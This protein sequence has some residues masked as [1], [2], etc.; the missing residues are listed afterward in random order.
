MTRQQEAPL[1][2]APIEEALAPEEAVQGSSNMVSVL[3]V[4]APG[5]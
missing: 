3:E 2:A 5:V 1:V 4:Q